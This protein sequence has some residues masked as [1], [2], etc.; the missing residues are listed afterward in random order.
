MTDGT[1][2]AP[3][4]DN[5]A[6][7]KPSAAETGGTVYSGPAPTQGS[8]SAPNYSSAPVRTAVSPYVVN[9]ASWF[10]WIAALS[11]VNSAISLSGSHW[12]FII[13]MGVTE[14]V[15]VIGGTTGP[16]G[17][18]AAF[19]INLFIAGIVA[20]FGVFA[21]RGQK[22]AF[23]VGGILYALD[24]LLLLAFKDFLSAAF[25]AYALFYIFRGFKHT[26]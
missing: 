2:P 8:P 11:L 19:V 20:L 24:G 22:W 3:K 23:L 9:G 25:H 13:G 15:D 26:D 4:M 10:I 17:R 12:H 7:G 21:R 6:F 16:T 18:V 1:G 5:Q 14:A